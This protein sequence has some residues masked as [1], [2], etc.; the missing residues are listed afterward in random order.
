[1]DIKLIHFKITLKNA[2]MKK[3]NN[4]FNSKNLNPFPMR[5]FK[6]LI[7]NFK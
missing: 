4:N 2:V 3:K 7:N 5:K 6:L 1:M